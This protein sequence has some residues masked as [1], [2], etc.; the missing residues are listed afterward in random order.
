MRGMSSKADNIY[1]GG[2]RSLQIFSDME[3]FCSYV[4]HGGNSK[5]YTRLGYLQSMHALIEI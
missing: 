3:V 5:R 4:I 1:I 2:A